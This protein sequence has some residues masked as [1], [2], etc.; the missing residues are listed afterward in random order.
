MA[1]KLRWVEGQ[2]EGRGRWRKTYRGRQFSF[3]AKGE[4]KRLSEVAAQ[5]AL[6]SFMARVDAEIDAK[7]APAKLLKRLQESQ[8]LLFETFHDTES[9]RSHW[10]GLQRLKNE[11]SQSLDGDDS[12]K[13]QAT[14]ERRFVHLN[15]A[16]LDKVPR[17]IRLS[18]RDE[19]GNWV[20]GENAATVPPE[21]PEGDAP[22]QAPETA[23]GLS[24]GDLHRRFLDSRMQDVKLGTLSAKRLD[25]IRLHTVYFVEWVGR[26][27]KV[28]TLSA[29]KVSE[30]FD[31]VR[32]LCSTEK[33]AHVTGRDRWNLA[34]A[35]L[36]WAYSSGFVDELPRSLQKKWSLGVQLRTIRTVDRSEIAVLLAN[37]SA[38]LRLFIL[39]GLN[40]GFTQT[41]LADLKRDEIDLEAETITRKRSKTRVHEGV[42]T[43]VYSLW[44]EVVSLLR[45]EVET[46]GVLA[47][48]TET[49]APLV[50]NE[51]GADAKM[52]NRTDSVALA[53][54]RLA[55]KTGIQAT[56]KTFRKTGSSTLE[57]RADFAHFDD[58]YLGHSPKSIAQKHYTKPDVKGFQ[59]AIAW[60]RLQLLEVAET[61]PATASMETAS[62]L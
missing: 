60:L 61:P 57:T 13:L 32:E 8:D 53:F 55:Q 10:E 19:N 5:R 15:L 47:F 45:T 26:N 49:G 21:T 59:V 44:P 41:D 58:L 62:G 11:V 4:S 48:L 56:F 18:Y 28:K 42:P 22:W 39:L 30:Y 38:R 50:R 17:F 31:H 20:R 36:E 27:C 29:S 25:L 2:G 40:C 34:K 43:V 7:S 35:F 52:K 37:A 24:L 23:S 54:N 51:V 1:E 33:L 14:I 6:K 16:Y 12:E 46:K 3:S 9:L